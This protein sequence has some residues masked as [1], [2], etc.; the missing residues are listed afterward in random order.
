M[1]KAI[2]FDK[3]GVLNI[4]NGVE[5]NLKKLELFPWSGDIIAEFRNQN[6][7]IFIVTNQPVVARG[8]IAEKELNDTFKQFQELIK[9]QNNNALIDRIYYCPHHPNGD[10]REYRKTCECRKP[11]PGMLVRASKEYNIDLNKS[12]MV[13][14][15]ISDIIAGNLAGCKTIQL[16]SGK[17]NESQIE[18]DLVLDEKI[19][20]D[21][22][23]TNIYELRKI[24]L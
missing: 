16:L 10:L 20:P 14:D 21:F 17:H 9:R 8:L 15:R 2:F 3:D 6:F 4:D 1:N 19:E 24:I 18:S 11:K 13:G 7:K 12:Y 5:D 22:K 23:I